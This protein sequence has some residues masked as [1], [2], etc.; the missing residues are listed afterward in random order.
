MRLLMYLEMSQLYVLP[1]FMHLHWLVL[2]AFRIFSF[3]NSLFRFSKFVF[4]IGDV[5]L[6]KLLGVV[7]IPCPCKAMFFWRPFLERHFSFWIRSMISL[8]QFLK[9]NRNFEIS[10]SFFW[11]TASQVHHLCLWEIPHFENS[12]MCCGACLTICGSCKHWVSLRLLI[13]LRSIVRFRSTLS[14]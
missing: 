12:S 3:T 7:P 9:M 5:L 13:L 2:F 14:Q 4:F 11:K 10:C 6:I 8:L 1:T